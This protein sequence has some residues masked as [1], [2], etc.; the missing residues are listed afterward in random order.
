MKNKTHFSL[1][2]YLKEC[3]TNSA[4]WLTK[5]KLL[6]NNKSNFNNSNKN[7]YKNNNKKNRSRNSSNSNNNK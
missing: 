3:S 1:W 4:Q 2:A 6:Y 5:I 7:Y